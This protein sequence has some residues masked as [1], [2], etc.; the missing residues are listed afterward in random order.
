MADGFRRNCEDVRPALAVQ[1][2]SDL[3]PPDL[4]VSEAPRP[5]EQD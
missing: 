3:R 5:A 1:P 2:T 4:V